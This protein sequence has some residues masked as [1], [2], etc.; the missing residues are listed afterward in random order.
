MRPWINVFVVLFVV[1]LMAAFV[2]SSIMTVISASTA[3]QQSIDAFDDLA[4]AEHMDECD[5][6]AAAPC[7]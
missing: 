2:L 5:P 1:G 7:F 4:H 6:F 3:L